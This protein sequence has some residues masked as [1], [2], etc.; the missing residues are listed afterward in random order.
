VNVTSTAPRPI[1]DIEADLSC[2]LSTKAAGDDTVDDAIVAAHVELAGRAPHVA[3]VEF[4]DD[5]IVV[6][7]ST[8]QELDERLAVI[9]V[10]IR[11]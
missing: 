5:T 4:D 2:L 10:D 9:G 6:S 3:V 8:E 7:A 11:A 1:A